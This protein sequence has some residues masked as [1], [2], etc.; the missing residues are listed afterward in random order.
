MTSETWCWS[1]VQYK[2]SRRT[3][4]REISIQYCKVMKTMTTTHTR[5]KVVNLVRS[6]YKWSLYKHFAWIRTS[7]F[8]NLYLLSHFSEVYLG[9]GYRNDQR[10][11]LFKFYQVTLSNTM[12]LT[13][14]SKKTCRSKSLFI[15][16]A[17]ASHHSVHW[18]DVLIV[19]IYLISPSSK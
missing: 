17:I 11:L 12:H 1:T 15:C 6:Q 9:H 8:L 10:R 2:I 3:S 7:K 4:N 19:S 18:S 13:Q 14:Y 5:N 16:W